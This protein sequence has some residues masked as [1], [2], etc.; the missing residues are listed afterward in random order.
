MRYRQVGT[1]A[2]WLLLAVA[3]LLTLFPLYWTVVLATRKAV[4][5]FSDPVFFF[6]PSFASFAEVWQNQDFVASLA[7][8]ASVVGL[9]VAIVLLIS[10]PAAYIFTRRNI[11]A[12]S[13]IFSWLLIAYLLPDFL[14]AIP[15]YSIYQNVGLYDSALG[16]AIAYQVFMAPLAMGLLLKFFQ[17]VPKELAEAS[18]VDGCSEFQ[19][20]WRIYLPVVMP[21]IATTAIL[22]AITVW[23]EVTIA[24][25]LTSN[26]P[27]V[28]IAVTTYKGYAS[29]QWDQLAAASLIAVFPVLIFA[30][31]VQ[32][33]IVKGL[34]AGIGK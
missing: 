32:R 9:T 21:G 22:V 10:V 34:T 4:D 7:M 33:L 6:V 28:A 31:L 1:V 20:M 13:G 26:N 14:I 8:S 19:T 2:R 30:M 12:K 18:I 25:A 17:D 29:I 3:I 23:N 5:A 27:T 15:M 24:L 16:L 11:R